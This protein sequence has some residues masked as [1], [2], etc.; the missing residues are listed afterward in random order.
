VALAAVL[1]VNAAV[2]IPI[3][4]GWWSVFALVGLYWFENVTL[5]VIQFLRMRRVERTQT[6]RDEFGMSGFFALHYGIFTLVHGIFVGVFFGL[7][8]D[9]AH[10]GGASGWWLS[11][12]LVAL[13]P[14]L[15]YRRDYVRGD[16]ARTANLNRLMFEPYA[17]V[18][19]M[20]LVVLVGAWIALS[21]Q[22]PRQL[23]LLLV[24]L[25]LTVE[26][27]SAWRSAR[28]SQATIAASQ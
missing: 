20:H 12:L 7:L 25:K 13:L 10:A 5:G 14:A 1:V 28:A 16:A 2:A 15:A 27:F 9:G 3:W 26:L 18:M 22:Q 19:V 11:A 8:L 17:R 21:T 24:G 23:L 4:L 6:R